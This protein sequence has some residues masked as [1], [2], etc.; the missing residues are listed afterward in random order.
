MKFKNRLTSLVALSALG[1]SDA[2]S[3][4]AQ[5]ADY[6]EQGWSSADRHYFYRTT[7][8][9]RLMPYRIFVNLEM[10]D[11]SER[12][13]SVPNL[14][15][16]GYL[17]DS[18]TSDN[19]D[20]LPIGFVKDTQVFAQDNVGLTCAACHTRDVTVKSSA[21]GLSRRIR[22]DGGQAYVD[23]ER[24]LR[25]LEAALRKPTVDEAAFVR[26]RVAAKVPLLSTLS[27]RQDVLAA[28]NK[29]KEENASQ[30]S[31]TESNVLVNP[32]PGRLDALAHIKNR[33]ANYVLANSY[34]HPGNNIDATAPASFPFLWD[35]PYLDFVQLPGNAPNAGIGSYLRNL[36]EVTGAFAETFVTGSG[37]VVL[38]TGTA[39][40]GNLVEL[41][42]R[43]LKLKSPQ[44]P[45]ADAP[46]NQTKVAQGDA[47]FGQYCSSCHVEVDRSP[48]NT[49]ITTYSVG[50][51]LLGTDPQQANNNL[52]DL[53]PAGRTNLNPQKLV[54][55]TQILGAV[56]ASQAAAQVFRYADLNAS[57]KQ[58]SPAPVRQVEV[59][60]DTS[61][62]R[63]PSRDESP[64]HTYKARP[65]NGI[66][67]TGPFLHNG[68]VRTLADLMLPASQR[69]ASFCVGS[70]ELDTVG[71]GMK[72]DCNVANAYRLDTSLP[73]NR[74]TGHEYGTASDNRVLAGRP[75]F[76]ALTQSERDA[77]VEYMKTL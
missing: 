13:A 68:S 26:L 3:V 66:W 11:S 51:D 59:R 17:F 12:F 38:S 7:Q 31:N 52:R 72:S 36:G 73:G 30:R 19:P 28:Y 45:L 53:A 20:N 77:I 44:W 1:L 48:R 69:P 62:P 56:L 43:V 6:L 58:G 40:V 63:D 60:L 18:D 49:F 37:G 39:R 65:L 64:V 42:N 21:T 71:V 14:G 47:L 2:S 29:V 46:L 41:E 67:A 16:M 76:R 27:F 35:A 74:N 70:I 23:T 4:S 57:H 10:A 54:S 9:S 8:G 5:S 55:P 75:G 22:I 15:A 34:Q 32:G 61:V 50:A 24:F 25:E 33:V